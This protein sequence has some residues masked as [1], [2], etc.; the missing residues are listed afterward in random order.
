MSKETSSGTLSF[1]KLRL[2]VCKKVT[3]FSENSMQSS[4]AP[5]RG[6]NLSR[7]CLPIRSSPEKYD[8]AAFLSDPSWTKLQADPKAWPGLFHFAMVFTRD[9]ITNAGVYQ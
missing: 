9:M 2:T 5:T 1:S 3:I 7:T 8:D 4:R 6:F